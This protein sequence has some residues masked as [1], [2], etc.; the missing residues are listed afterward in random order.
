MV[1]A[2]R[3]MDVRFSITAR[4]LACAVSSRPYPA[5]LD[6][7]P[8][9]DGGRRRRGRNQLHS[10]PEQAR[11]R[12]GAAHRP[13]REAHARFPVGPLRH[14]QLSRLHHRQGGGNPGTGGRR[15]HAEIENAIRD[16]KYGVGLNHLPSGRFPANRLGWRCRWSPQPGSWTER[17]SGLGEQRD[18][19]DPATD[20]FPRKAHPLGARLTLH[21]PQRWPWEAVRPWR[22]SLDSE[23]CLPLLTAHDRHWPSGQLNAPPSPSRSRASLLRPRHLAR[24]NHCRPIVGPQ[25]ACRPPP[26]PRY[27]NSSPD[28]AFLT[29]LPAHSLR[30]V[31]SKGARF[32]VVQQFQMVLR[33]LIQMAPTAVATPSIVGNPTMRIILNKCQSPAT[34]T[35]QPVTLTTLAQIP[36]ASPSQTPLRMVVL[37][38][39]AAEAP[40]ATAAN[41]MLKSG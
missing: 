34:T 28:H 33:L 13:A 4:V 26:T 29:P 17:A 11:R 40:P 2:C 20:S 37:D 25:N 18:H 10:L 21:L 9:L 31:D 7:H 23:R 3:R 39:K 14:L 16:L 38:V 32:V 1:A 35:L 19:Q 36:S 12:A 22:P 6:A 41:A 15:R 27:P 8:L 5:G 24:N 30:A